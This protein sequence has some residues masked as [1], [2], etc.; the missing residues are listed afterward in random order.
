MASASEAQEAFLCVRRQRRE[1]RRRR[2]QQQQRQGPDLHITSVPPHI[3]IHQRR[4]ASG[5]L[6]PLQQALLAGAD[7]SSMPSCSQP[8]A[9]QRQPLELVGAVA[10]AADVSAC[11]GG[12]AA[13][14]LLVAACALL[15][16][17][18]IAAPF[19]VMM[20]GTLLAWGIGAQL[21]QAAARMRLLQAYCACSMILLYVFQLLPEA[22]MQSGA[23]RAAA[24]MR[25][26][27][28]YRLAS[29]TPVAQLVPQLLHMVALFTLYG[30][31]AIMLTRS[32]LG[33]AAPGRPS[34][35]A[36][37]T[38]AHAGGAAAL[39][40]SL[41][42]SLESLCASHPTTLAV[43]LCCFSMGQVCVLSGVALVV[44][45]WTLLAPSRWGRG[46][47]NTQ[48]EGAAVRAFSGCCFG[49]PIITTRVT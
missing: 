35:S 2:Q 17:S 21:R 14:M 25:V 34:S 33:A 19:L 20:S 40:L 41:L 7:S 16:P 49:R 6:A 47:M 37:A 22:G 42:R 45:M 9:A 46:N 13:T 27:G 4:E 28:L 8:E 26:L 1:A 32:M 10:A 18:P 44:G 11:T 36:A 43:A 5:E 39:P 29:A 31:S 38:A 3:G 48:Q 24:K 15:W 12:E 23:A 30:N